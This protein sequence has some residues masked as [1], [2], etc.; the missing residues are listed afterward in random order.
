VGGG[1]FLGLRTEGTRPGAEHLTLLVQDGVEGGLTLTN[2]ADGGSFHA[3]IRLYRSSVPRLASRA[4]AVPGGAPRSIGEPRLGSAGVSWLV[5][6]LGLV[7]PA[8]EGA[9]SRCSRASRRR[10]RGQGLQG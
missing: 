7:K 4:R 8:G 5:A 10:E 6:A 1:T 3:D 9:R 2:R